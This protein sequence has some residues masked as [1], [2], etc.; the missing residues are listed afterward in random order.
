MH[1][2]VQQ[3]ANARSRNL[4]LLPQRPLLIVETFAGYVSLVEAHV[5][6]GLG[7]RVNAILLP[8]V[9]SRVE[10]VRVITQG[11]PPLQPAPLRKLR[12]AAPHFPILQVSLLLLR[13]CPYSP[14]IAL[15]PSS[16]Q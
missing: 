4:L 6:R 5:M 10:P 8:Y 3:L 2:D 12:V 9:L 13:E 15:Q 14:S 16:L 7:Q 1:V 11:R